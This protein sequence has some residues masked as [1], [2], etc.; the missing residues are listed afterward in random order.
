MLK[1]SRS[2][3]IQS[4][5]PFLHFHLSGSVRVMAKSSWRIIMKNLS[6][7][8]EDCELYPYFA[9]T[10]RPSDTL[11]SCWSQNVPN[12]RVSQNNTLHP[13]LSF[14]NYQL[15][16]EWGRK[17]KTLSLSVFEVMTQSLSTFIYMHLIIRYL[18]IYFHSEINLIVFDLKELLQGTGTTVSSSVKYKVVGY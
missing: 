3:H 13:S 1:A 6:L 5:Q 7:K 18:K 11:S 17:Q 2:R 16:T 15:F 8:D 12:E 14:V 4:G 10:Y 9:W